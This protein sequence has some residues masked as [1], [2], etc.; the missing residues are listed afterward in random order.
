MEQINIDSYISILDNLEAKKSSK[1]KRKLNNLNKKQFNVVFLLDSKNIT[2]IKNSSNNINKNNKIDIISKMYNNNLLTIERLQFIMKYCINYFNISSDL[3][4]KLLKDE[5]VTLLDVIFS[6]FKFYDNK[7]IL[8]LLLY[9]NNKTTISISN[10][11]Q[12]I[13]KDKLKFQ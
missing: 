10:L 7:F 5:K 8:Q 4:K 3:I 11:Y 9:Y 2:E 6:N 1:K 13:S 12:Q